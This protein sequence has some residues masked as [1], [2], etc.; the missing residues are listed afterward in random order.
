MPDERWR[1][2]KEWSAWYTATRDEPLDDE[3]LA[4]MPELP[5]MDAA[6]RVLLMMD[7][8]T[9]RG[10]GFLVRAL[11]GQGALLPMPCPGGG[12]SAAWNH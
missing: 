10:Q 5:D 3:R 7:F 6:C 9:V 8:C 1:K 12:S 11:A 4:S 2:M